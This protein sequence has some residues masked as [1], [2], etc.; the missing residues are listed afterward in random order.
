MTT[1]SYSD[2]METNDS[3]SAEESEEI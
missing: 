2:R 3:R 1:M